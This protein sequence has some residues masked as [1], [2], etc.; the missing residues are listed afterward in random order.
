MNT[1]PIGP[2]IHGA[3][4]YGFVA[5]QALAPNIFN[6]KGSA[7]TLCYTFAATQGVI[8]SFTNY[9][10]GLKRL[11]PFHLHKQIETPVLPALVVLPW[12]TG[13]F[14]EGKARR[15]FLAS[16]GIALATYL[17]TDYRAYQK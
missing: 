14:K 17:L 7:R 5:M 4:D 8:N 16:F 11:I 15:F 12:I 3:I 9:P 10:L 13:A 6:L 1:K 2:K